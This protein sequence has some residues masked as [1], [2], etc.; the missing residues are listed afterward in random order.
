V[1][2]RGEAVAYDGVSPVGWRVAAYVLVLRGGRVLLLAKA[3]GGWDELPGGAVRP[4]ETLP[5][6]A[7]RECLEE[8]GYRFAAA[9]FAP[10]HVAEQFFFHRGART[11][12]HSLLVV[13]PGAVTREREAGW[14]PEGGG[15]DPVRWVDPTTLAEAR[16]NPNHWPALVKAGVI[17]SG[18]RGRADTGGIVQP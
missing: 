7:A 14:Q 15:P 1:N 6:G 11:Y 13:L 3:F 16:T 8:T 5:E 12:H 2:A 4:E 9:A 17:P 18:G 10:V